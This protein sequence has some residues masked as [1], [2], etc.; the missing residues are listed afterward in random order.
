M[1]W[2]REV[3]TDRGTF[4]QRHK[5][6]KGTR[7]LLFWKKNIQE[8]G[9]KVHKFGGESVV[10]KLQRVEYAQKKVGMEEY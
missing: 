2:G 5:S 3:F 10:S 9:L 4:K 8:E 7:H 1:G 6:R